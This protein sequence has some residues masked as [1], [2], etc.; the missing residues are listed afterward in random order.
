MTEGRQLRTKAN[1]SQSS[2]CGQEQPSAF[3]IKVFGAVVVDERVDQ[4]TD[5]V[6]NVSGPVMSSQGFAVFAVD[7]RGGC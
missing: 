4:W 1:N 2:D 5:D 6:S 3:V 7:G